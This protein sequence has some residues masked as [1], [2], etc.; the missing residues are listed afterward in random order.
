MNTLLK[1]FAASLAL[2]LA[3]GM[4]HPPAVAQTKTTTAPAAT[5]L[6]DGEVRKLDAA[7]GTITLKHGE[8]KNLDMPPMT[9]VFKVKDR[10]W[11]APLKV[12]DKVRFRAEMKGD[13]MVVTVLQPVR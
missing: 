8:I 12:G 5:D 7:T 2:A 13:D 6:T 1:T 10:A 3:L 9:M 11:L 4:P